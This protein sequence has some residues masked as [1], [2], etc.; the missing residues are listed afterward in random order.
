MRLQDHFILRMFLASALLGDGLGVAR[1]VEIPK[2]KPVI[3]IPKPTINVPKPTVNIPKATIQKPPVVVVK[4]TKPVTST[5]ERDTGGKKPVGVSREV[6][7]PKERGAPQSSGNTLTVAPKSNTDGVAV[8]LPKSDMGGPPNASATGASSRPVLAGADKPK[9]RPMSP[10][11]FSALGSGGDD[12]DDDDSARPGLRPASLTS[13]KSTTQPKIKPMSLAKLATG[14]GDDDDDDDA[15]TPGSGAS[16]AKSNGKGLTLSQNKSAIKVKAAAKMAE[17]ADDTGDDDDDDDSS[18]APPPKKQPI[19]MGGGDDDDDDDDSSGT[20]NQKGSGSG[21]QTVNI[22]G[23]SVSINGS[24][25]TVNGPNGSISASYNGNGTFTINANGTTVTVNS[26]DL[27]AIKNGDYSSISALLPSM[28]DRSFPSTISSIGSATNGAGYA[29]IVNTS[30][31]QNLQN[32]LQQDLQTPYN[33]PQMSAAPYPTPSYNGPDPGVITYAGSSINALGAQFGV[34][35]S[36]SDGSSSGTNYQLQLSAGYSAPGPSVY[37]ATTN[38]AQG[39]AEGLS[40]N[41]GSLMVSPSGGTAAISGTPASMVSMGVSFGIPISATAAQ[42]LGSYFSNTPP[43]YPSAA[44]AT[45]Q[46]SAPSS[47]PPPTQPLP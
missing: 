3:N 46:P 23:N 38:D 31:Q 5:T 2:P 14:G 42:T 40:A 47:P 25:A 13:N 12:D 17:A 35:V 41:I 24:T 7:R 4:P 11:K 1:A 44:G 39:V 45:I 21:N 27:A 29:S 22:D 33:G 32:S 43:T 34:G 8:S 18:G 37:V 20:A 15:A 30:I 36:R 6:D 19:T 26:Q 10:T 28:I 16:T 9:V